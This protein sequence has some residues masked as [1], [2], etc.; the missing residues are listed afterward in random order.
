MNTPL[1]SLS[2]AKG[3][4]GTSTTAA[5]LA[6]ASGTKTLLVDNSSS[7]DLAAILGLATPTK[8]LTKVTDLVDLYIGDDPDTDSYDLVIADQ[9]TNTDTV[10]GATNYLVTRRCYLSMRKALNLPFD[11]LIVVDESQRALTVKDLQ[12]VT[13]APIA[14]TVAYD[15]ALSRAVDAGLLVSRASSFYGGIADISRGV[16]VAA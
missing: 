6:L 2:A 4:T 3:G 15:P 5:L 1:I 8:V 9:G 14:G 16:V 10:K 11:G 13:G 7:R 12:H